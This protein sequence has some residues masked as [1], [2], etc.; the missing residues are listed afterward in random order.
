MQ[1]CH[2]PVTDKFYAADP[3]EM[4]DDRIIVCEIHYYVRR[5][6]LCKQCEK[7]LRAGAPAETVGRFKY[8]EQCIKCPGCLLALHAPPSPLSQSQHHHH[9]SYHRR[10]NTHSSPANTTT[11]SATDLINSKKDS[12]STTSWVHHDGRSYCRYHYSLLRGTECA[13][14]NQAIMLQ[15]IDDIQQDGKRWH[16]ECYMIQKVKI[17]GRL[18]MSA[19]LSLCLFIYPHASVFC[20]DKVL[21]CPSRHAG[22]GTTW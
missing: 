15:P 17:R 22:P 18:D 20:H 9:H 5:G 21:E 1:D 4:G 11:P 14:C 2:Q 13:G 3:D 10:H 7:P 12:E 19:S 16:H 6:L 8:H